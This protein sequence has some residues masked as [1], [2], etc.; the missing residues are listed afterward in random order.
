M[1]NKT[2]SVWQTGITS[3][4]GGGGGCGVEIKGT[5]WK[6]PVNLLKDKLLEEPR[7]QTFKKRK[8]EGRTKEFH[9]DLQPYMSNVL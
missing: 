6:I 9:R 5:V 7:Y 4:T 2:P 8:G 3:Y 1:P